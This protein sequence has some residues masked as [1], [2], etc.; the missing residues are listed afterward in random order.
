[1]F[2]ST[3]IGY[4]IFRNIACGLIQFIFQIKT[5]FFR[6]IF[7]LILVEMLFIRV[8]S[9]CD[10]NKKCIYLMCWIWHSA[11][12]TFQFY[13]YLNPSSKT[14]SASATYYYSQTRNSKY[15]SNAI[16]PSSSCYSMICCFLVGVPMGNCVHMYYIISHLII[17]TYHW[18]TSLTPYVMC[19]DIYL[20]Y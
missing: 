11:P 1:M 16:I 15:Y 17:L 4:L 5:T 13:Y 14:T 7:H 20:E 6:I 9:L 10:I 3:Q 12:N 19:L 8:V 2:F 18:T